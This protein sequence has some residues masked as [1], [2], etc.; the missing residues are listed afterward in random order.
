MTDACFNLETPPGVPAKKKQKK[1]KVFL[2]KDSAKNTQS[3][4]Y[5]GSSVLKD[6]NLYGKAMST[7]VHVRRYL[8]VLS[9]LKPETRAIYG[10]TVSTKFKINLLSYSSAAHRPMAAA[11]HAYSLATSILASA[12]VRIYYLLSYLLLLRH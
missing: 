6:L 2:P 3:I 1:G 4:L 7:K 10:R 8:F 12:A 9:T 5:T 11:P